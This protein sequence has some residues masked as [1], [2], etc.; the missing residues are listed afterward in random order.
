MG[1]DEIK[2]SPTISIGVSPIS[3][4]NLIK[5]SSHAIQDVFHMPLL[6]VLF[7]MKSPWPTGS[8]QKRHLMV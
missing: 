7:Q 8:V 1:C 5:I 6:A 4:S 2:L 3:H